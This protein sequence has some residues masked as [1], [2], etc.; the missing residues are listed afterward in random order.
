MEQRKRHR[1]TLTS[2][3]NVYKISYCGRT[4]GAHSMTHALDLIAILYYIYEGAK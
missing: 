2:Q 1:I 3:G 4:W